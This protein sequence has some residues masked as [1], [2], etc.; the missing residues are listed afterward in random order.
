MTAQDYVNNTPH[1]QQDNSKLGVGMQIGG[2]ATA[3]AGIGGFY[4][5]S[6]KYKNTDPVDLLDD[7]DKRTIQ[8]QTYNLTE[9]LHK[10]MP[11]IS[12]DKLE[13]TAK[14]RVLLNLEKSLEEKPINELKTEGYGD[15]T[16]RGARKL[17]F[18]NLLR[19]HGIK[20]GLGGV[21]VAAAGK[22]YDTFR[23]KEKHE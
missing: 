5:G 22:L 15:G 14:N 17:R 12:R 8:I 19:K 13:E 11:F 16:I 10:E 9:E 21:G 1:K 2:L 4:Y 7:Y 20:V 3:G 23:D 6:H 18:Y